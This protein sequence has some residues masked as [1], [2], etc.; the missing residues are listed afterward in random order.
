MTY[1]VIP[2]SL[3]IG[4]SLALLMR[5]V[6]TVSSSEN[7]LN[8]QNTE[9]ER[10]EKSFKGYLVL[11]YL[12]GASLTIHERLAT[13]FGVSIGTGLIA[14][15]T[16][17]LGNDLSLDQSKSAM[18]GLILGNLSLSYFLKTSPLITYSLIGTAIVWYGCAEFFYL[19]SK[20]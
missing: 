14:K 16:Y 3:L 13:G 15:L 6:D 20:I 9:I 7:N 18:G 8:R 11:S 4:S 2:S 5:E 1:S 19:A 10:K 17:H 12:L